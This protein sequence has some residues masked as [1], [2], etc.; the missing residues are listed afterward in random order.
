MK[1]LEIVKRGDFEKIQTPVQFERPIDIISREHWE[2]LKSPTKITHGRWEQFQ[3]HSKPMAEIA[4]SMQM[5][6]MRAAREMAT[7]A[8]FKD[9]KKEVVQNCPATQEIE[10]DTSTFAI[11]LRKHME[12]A[13]QNQEIGNQVMAI[14]AIFGDMPF[15][16][17]MMILQAFIQEH[18]RK[19]TNQPETISA[20]PETPAQPLQSETP[21]EN[22][23][24]AYGLKGKEKQLQ[25]NVKEKFRLGKFQELFPIWAA[26]LQSQEYGVQAKFIAIVQAHYDEY[27]DDLI[28]KDVK[29]SEKDKV[30]NP[31]AVRR[32]LK[33][34]EH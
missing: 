16:E 31:D 32:W 2:K 3:R 30:L 24:R 26:R 9:I 33:R 5:E 20:L 34:M 1:L 4:A 8:T 10:I 12:M 28:A 15:N 14:R 6:T 21:I 18:Q 23:A 22:M 11:G 19:Q 17:V 7:V 13:G 25:N 29:M 27:I